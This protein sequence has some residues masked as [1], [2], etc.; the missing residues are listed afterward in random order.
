LP[1]KCELARRTRCSIIL[2]FV[3]YNVTKRAP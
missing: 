1:I 2:L 3:S